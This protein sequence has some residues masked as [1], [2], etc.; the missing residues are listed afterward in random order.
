MVA[1]RVRQTAGE[2]ADETACYLAEMTGGLMVRS[3]AEMKG[4]EMADVTVAR[5]A[6][7]LVARMVPKMDNWKV[8]M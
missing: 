5:W 7:S 3:M 2:T 6:D 1:R 4:S 8:V